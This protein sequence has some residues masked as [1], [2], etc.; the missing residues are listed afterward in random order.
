MQ[1]GGNWVHAVYSEYFPDM[2][3]GVA[4]APIPAKYGGT[5]PGSCMGS[6][7]L[8]IPR[9]IKSP[10][11]E[12]A[13]EYLRWMCG[14]DAMRQFCKQADQLP[15]RKDVSDDPYFRRDAQMI[16]WIDLMPCGFNRPSIAEGQLLWTELLAAEDKAVHGL[17]TPKQLLDGVAATIDEAME[18]WQM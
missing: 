8:A 4:R 6:E 18:K 3:W 17:G 1:M 2:D 7:G 15:T 5:S 10:Y 16:A 14:P 11:R 12:A 9:G 13:W